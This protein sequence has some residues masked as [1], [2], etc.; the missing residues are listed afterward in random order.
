MLIYN[1][2]PSKFSNYQR[3]LLYNPQCHL[4]SGRYCP[5]T[6]PILQ[7]HLVPHCS[8][9]WLDL[10]SFIEEEKISE[11]WLDFSQFAFRVLLLVFSR[12]MVFAW[13][14]WELAQMADNSS[15]RSNECEIENASRKLVLWKKMSKCYIVPCEN[16]KKKFPVRCARGVREK[17]ASEGYWN[18]VK[19]NRHQILSGAC[20]AG[21]RCYAVG[22]VEGIPFTVSCYGFMTGA[23]APRD[24]MSGWR[25]PDIDFPSDYLDRTA[26]KTQVRVSWWLVLTLRSPRLSL[27]WRARVIVPRPLEREQATEFGATATRSSLGRFKI[28]CGFQMED[29]SCYDKAN[30]SQRCLAYLVKGGCR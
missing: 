4:P 19:M 23:L 9:Y 24:R 8:Y 28:V 15:F 6:T 26:L 16:W 10:S 2:T 1:K 30:V 25:M 13:V 14:E 7:N 5:R 18:L 11:C 22:S 21:D 17:C 20:N 27:Q 12:F 29:L 3:Q